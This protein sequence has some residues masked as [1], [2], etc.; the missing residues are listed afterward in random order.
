MRAKL[1]FKFVFVYLFKL[2]FK[3]IQLQKIKKENND[4]VRKKVQWGE[5]E[6]Q[7]I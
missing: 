6:K 2:N 4:L 3:T 1:D 7:R 5:I